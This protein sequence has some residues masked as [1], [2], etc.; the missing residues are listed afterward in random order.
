[1]P[2]ISLE[3]VAHSFTVVNVDIHVDTPNGKLF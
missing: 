1:M 2:E 3:S